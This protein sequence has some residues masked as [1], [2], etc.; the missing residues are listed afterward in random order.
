MQRD[1]YGWRSPRLG[2]EM[3]IAQYGHWGHALLLYPT[4]DADFL[5]CERF[6]LIEAIRPQI[7]AGKVRVFS[8]NSINRYAWTSKP[9]PMH[10]K[11]YRQA[12]FSAYVEEEVVPHIRRVLQDPDAR[13]T[14]CGASFG[15]FHAANQF[16]RRP[17][18]FDG[19][20]GMSGMYDLADVLYDYSDENCYFNNPS[21]FVP[22]MHDGHQ[23]DLIR[24]HSQIHILGGQ[25]NWERPHMAK[26]FS[27]K[28]WDRGI[29][30]NLDL[31]GY[32]MAHDWPTWRRMLPY[33]IE[34][35][36]GW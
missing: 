30:H 9:V 4:A 28:L 21:W 23:L 3:P 16:F 20:I 13:I 19:M 32:D 27:Q 8:I 14:T 24:N 31:W 34:N 10:E 25:G 2:I 33:Y 15:A 18:L 6:H 5:D 17:D 12:L 22:N 26:N 36:L 11:A 7:D 35:R 1:L 29:A